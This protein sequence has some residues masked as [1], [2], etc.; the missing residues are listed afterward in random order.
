[1]QAIAARSAAP[2]R[3]AVRA[4]LRT[5][6]RNFGGGGDVTDVR[7]LLTLFSTFFGLCMWAHDDIPTAKGEAAAVW[8]GRW[9]GIGGVCAR[10]GGSGLPAHRGL[11]A[12]HCV[13]CRANRA[14]E[15]GHRW[16]RAL[17]RAAFGGMVCVGGGGG[18][19][20]PCTN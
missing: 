13:R 15:A 5:Q 2:L 6:R 18:R 4:P 20:A 12:L 10:H 1:M 17:I 7:P 8:A 11:L 9:A 3:Q 16:H 19:G 14:C